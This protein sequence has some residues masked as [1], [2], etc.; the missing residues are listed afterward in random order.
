MM[1]TAGLFEGNVMLVLVS[2]LAAAASVPTA[3][4]AQKDDDPIICTKVNVGD[5]VGT[6]MRTKKKVC[7][8]KSDRAYIDQQEK[9]AI[10]HLV[11]DGD[12]RMVAPVGAPR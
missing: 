5:E 7:M 8:H 4:P 11:N 9:Q 3:Q 12:A 1:E 10:Q 6:R 2:A